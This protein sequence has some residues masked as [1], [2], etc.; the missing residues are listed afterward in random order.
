MYILAKKCENKFSLI[1]A[2]NYLNES[3]E[4]IFLNISVILKI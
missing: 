3:I 2:E 4:I 1:K